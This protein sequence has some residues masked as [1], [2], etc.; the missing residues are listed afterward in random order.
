MKKNFFYLAIAACVALCNIS[1]G[2][3]D[4]GGSGEPIK[5]L[6]YA[7]QAVAFIVNNGTVTAS[8]GDSN[9]SLTAMNFTEAGK[10]VLEITENGQKKFVTYNVKIE[11]NTYTITDDNGK[12][13]GTVQSNV[14]RGSKSAVININIKITVNGQTYTFT[15][16]SADATMQ[17]AT[18]TGGNNLATIART[19][20]VKNMKLTVESADP[21][22]VSISM[23]E[24]S[25]K[26]SSFVAEI[27]KRDTGFSDSDIDKL[28]KEIKS[29]TLDQT[30]MFDIEYT[31]GGSDVA[32]WSWK[33]NN[34]ANIALEL[35]NNEA[36]N[37]FIQNNTNITVTLTSKLCN[38]MFVTQIER[39]GKEALIGTLQVAMEPK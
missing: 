34:Y 2:S 37:K 28:N 17:Y 7:N 3:D 23:T 1:C 18:M 27:K 4:G 24:Q 21:D 10:A 32:T 16:N 35:K 5:P 20:V 11:G 31:N 36:G 29:L 14:T 13:I 15:T 39:R 22:F 30:G 6:E 38:F 9:T 19:W 12:V 33:G 25:G 26:L 8:E